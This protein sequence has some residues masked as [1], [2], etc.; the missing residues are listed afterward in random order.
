MVGGSSPAVGLDPPELYSNK[1]FYICSDFKY[2]I[3]KL[4]FALKF[5]LE[6]GG[7]IDSVY[8][9]GETYISLVFEVLSSF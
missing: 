7:Q 1:W 3:F 9:T 5:A 4:L 8:T 6:V 2:L